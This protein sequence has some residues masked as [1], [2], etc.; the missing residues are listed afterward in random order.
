MVAVT[1]GTETG[2]KHIGS[3]RYSVGEHKGSLVVEVCCQPEV[4]VRLEIEVQE[5]GCIVALKVQGHIC[6][7]GVHWM[8]VEHYTEIGHD[9]L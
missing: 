5:A 7:K 9:E 1:S 3:G 4:E 8:A 6:L 2:L